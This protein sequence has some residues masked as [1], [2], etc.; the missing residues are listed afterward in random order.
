MDRALSIFAI[1]WGSG[2]VALNLLGIAGA[3]VAY[4]FWEAVFRIQDWYSPFNIVNWGLNL[5]LVS[6]ALGAFLWRERRRAKSGT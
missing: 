4:P 1:V 6:P 2:V 3:F 5:V